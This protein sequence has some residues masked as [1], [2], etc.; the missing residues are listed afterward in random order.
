MKYFPATARTAFE[1]PL[2]HNASARDRLSDSA[3]EPMT[4]PVS[5][6]AQPNYKDS[7]I[8]RSHILII[9][10]DA[11]I[12]LVLERVLCAAGYRVS[13]AEDGEAGWSELCAGSYDLLI[14]DHDMPRLS[15]LDLLRRLRAVKFDLPVILI[16]GDMPW[17]EADLWEM[18]QPGLALEKPFSFVE[19]MVK[20]RDLLSK[21]R[22]PEPVFEHSSSYAS[23]REQSPSLVSKW[24]NQPLPGILAGAG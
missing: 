11:D 18:L 16:S 14:T 1:G 13:S 5:S 17:A 24:G 3:L 2:L 19:L 8:V 23:G 4:A 21:A 15:G 12:R 7:V 22:S 9:D 10:D 6:F 20:V